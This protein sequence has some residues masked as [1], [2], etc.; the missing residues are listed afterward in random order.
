MQTR[1]SGQA[2]R[3]KS[4]LDAVGVPLSMASQVGHVAEC[5]GQGLHRTD[6]QCSNPVLCGAIALT[7]GQLREEGE[8]K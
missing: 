5:E 8:R 7:V 4:T 2:D 3:Q 6:Q 1:D